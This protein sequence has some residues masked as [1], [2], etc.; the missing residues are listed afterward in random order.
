MSVAETRCA[1]DPGAWA[2]KTSNME[3]M[4]SGTSL[5]LVPLTL[6]LGKLFPSEIRIPARPFV[7]GGA[8]AFSSVF[9]KIF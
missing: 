6:S 7:V 9:R 8:A 4:K 2:K 3:P 1:S 5:R